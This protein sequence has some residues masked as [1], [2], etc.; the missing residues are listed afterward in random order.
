[1]RLHELLERMVKN[2][3]SDMFVTAK[4]PV[5]AKINGE[6][7]PIDD[8]VLTAEQSLALVYDAMNE[9]QINQFD[10]EKECNFAIQIDEIGRFSYFRLLAT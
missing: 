5:S 6:L 2:D 8:A 1:M 9:K 4:L 7:Q 3:A 10:T